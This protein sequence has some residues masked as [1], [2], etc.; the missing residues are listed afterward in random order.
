[1]IDDIIVISDISLV[2]VVILVDLQI[3]KAHMFK[4][5]GYITWPASNNNKALFIIYVP[6]ECMIWVNSGHIYCMKTHTI[7]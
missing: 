2:S 3:K 7:A 6:F 1:M 4:N 5:G